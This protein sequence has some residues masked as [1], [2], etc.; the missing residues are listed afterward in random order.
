MKLSIDEIK[1][2]DRNAKDH[3]PKQIKLIAD[4]IKRFGFLQSIV[5]DKNNEIVAGHGRYEAAK[6]LGLKEVPVIKADTLT[7]QEIKAYRLA[8]N[9]IN[10]LTGFKMDLV[11]EEL[12]GLDDNLVD[13]TGFDCDILIESD[14]NDDIVLET[15]PTRTKLGDIWQLGKHR[16]MCGD[17]TKKK[18]VERLM[19]GKKADILITDPPYGVNYGDKNKF[20]NSIGKGNRIQDKISGDNIIGENYKKWSE[21][22]LIN[23]RDILENVFYIFISGKNIHELIG[24]INNLG[25]KYSQD[26]VWVKNNHILGRLDYNL[27]H[28]NIIYGW[29]DSHTDK[30]L[31]N[32]SVIDDEIDIRSLD[33]NALLSKVKQLQKALKQSIIRENKPLKSE[34]HSTMKPVG[35]IEKFIFDSTEVDNIILDFFL[36]SGST[37]IACE[38][39]NRICYGMEIAPKYVDIILQR[40]EQ[41]TNNKPIKIG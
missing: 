10:A 36:G 28:E 8:D 41:Y 17:S 31:F 7:E 27:K 3:N 39:T 24:A 29:L 9:Q 16:V 32:T 22:W 23:L 34:L 1:P 38:K 25:Y 6:F 18:D 4:S 20:L 12:K 30:G 19:D 11:I 21:S 26:L 2:Y 14:E 40:Y 33:K 5:I 35:L 15:A 13:L 37:L